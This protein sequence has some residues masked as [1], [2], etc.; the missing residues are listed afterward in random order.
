MTAAFVVEICIMV[1][2]D[3]PLMRDRGYYGTYFPEVKV[4]SR[5][6]V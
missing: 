6:V 2:A 4:T 1:L 5:Q 3:R